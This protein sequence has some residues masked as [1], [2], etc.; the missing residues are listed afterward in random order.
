M[1]E[2]AQKH[3]LKL[4]FVIISI[5]CTSFVADI[6]DSVKKIP[7]ISFKVDSMDN[8]LTKLEGKL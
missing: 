6:K 3:A 4:F 5:V 8:R 1:F 7:E 2:E